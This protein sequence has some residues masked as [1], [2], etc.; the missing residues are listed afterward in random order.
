MCSGDPL[1]EQAAAVTAAWSTEDRLVKLADLRQAVDAAMVAA[2][3]E[4]DGAPGMVMLDGS[5]DGGRWLASRSE[6]HPAEATG[7]ARLASDLPAM[8]AT[9]EAVEKGRIGVEKARLLASVRDLDGFDEAEAELVEQMVYVSYKAARR[10]VRRFR[11]DQEQPGE[12]DPC[13]LYT[14][15]SPRDS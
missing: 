14:S 8:P 1:V 12:A 10:I 6:I 15:P 7:L 11:A 3:V 4:I 5:V 2:L 13:L 9:G